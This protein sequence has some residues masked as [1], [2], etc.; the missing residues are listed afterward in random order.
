MN[1]EQHYL[2]T[3]N[4]EQ[5]QDLFFDASQNDEDIGAPNLNNCHDNENQH[6]VDLTL[7]PSQNL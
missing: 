3:I 2:Q 1:E 6:C 5:E 7:A 4:Q